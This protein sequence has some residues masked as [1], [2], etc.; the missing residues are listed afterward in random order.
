[1]RII[2]DNKQPEYESEVGKMS[3][4]EILD[5]KD[6]FLKIAVSKDVM[7]ELKQEIERNLKKLGDTERIP[8]DKADIIQLISFIEETKIRFL[9]GHIRAQQLYKEVDFKLCMF[10]RQYPEFDYLNDS[11]LNAYFA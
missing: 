5:I 11:V 2:T 10:K 7:D 4:V 6:H 9:Q 1:V 8:Y 3:I